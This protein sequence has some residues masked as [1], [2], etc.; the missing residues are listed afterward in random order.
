V[1]LGLENQVYIFNPLTMLFIILLAALAARPP[2]PR[3]K[4]AI[5]GGLVFSLGGDILLMVPKD[6]FILGLVS[7]L[8]AH[9]IYIYAFTLER[10]IRF[11]LLTLAP[12]IIYGIV[13]FLYLAPG[14]ETMTIPVMAYIAVILTMVWQAWEQWNHN[15]QRWA[16]LAFIGAIFFVLSDTSL[17]INKFKAPFEAEPFITI[18][19]YVAAQWLIAFS[20]RRGVK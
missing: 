12:F 4:K 9:L 16:L 15:R 10:K 18:V 1:Y 6:L 19:T 3:Y 5:I 14:L 13:I 8:I 2:L 17:A 7:F 20:I 11:N